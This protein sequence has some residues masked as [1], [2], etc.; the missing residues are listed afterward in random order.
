MSLVTVS[1]D[2]FCEGLKNNAPFYRLYVDNELLTERTWTW[3][4]YEVFIREQIE[5]DVD[6][7]SHTITLDN[8]NSP[9]VFKFKNP[10]INGQPFFANTIGQELSF[11]T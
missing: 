2:V 6:S 9:T 11:D 3:P 8:C 4:S 1:I 5:V 7:G 10:Q